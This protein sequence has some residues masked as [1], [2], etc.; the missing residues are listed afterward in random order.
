MKA[1]SQ[2]AGIQLFN[3]NRQIFKAPAPQGQSKE[4]RRVMIRLGP[5]HDARKVGAFELRQ[6][7]KELES[8]KS[9]VSDVWSVPSGV[10]I[11]APTPAKA[12][13]I[14]QSK[15]ARK[16]RMG[17]ATKVRCL[18]GTQDPME[19]LLQE[20][21]ATVRDYLPIRYMN[22]T[23]KSQNDEPYGNI[24][25]CVPKAKA[26]KFPSRLRIFGEDN[27]ERIEPSLRIMQ[28]NVGES[29]SAHN[30][31]LALAN[32]NSIDILLLLKLW[33]FTD[34]SIR[35]S[36]AHRSFTA[37]SNARLELQ[38]ETTDLSR[39]ILQITITMGDHRWAPIWNI[40][41]APVR[42]DE[43][44]SDLDLLLKSPNLPFYV[45]GDFNLRHPLRDMTNTSPHMA[46]QELIN[47]YNSLD[48]IL[49]NTR[50]PPTN[51]RDGTIDLVFSMDENAKCEV[52]KDLHTT[53]DHETLVTT[54]RIKKLQNSKGKLRYRDLDNEIFLRLLSN[55][56]IPLT[57]ACPRTRPPNGDTPCWNSECQA[58][59]SG[60]I[61]LE[62]K[63]LRDAVQ[64]LKRAYWRSIIEE[65]EKLS[66]VYKIVRWHKAS[67]NYLLPPL[68]DT[69]GQECAQDPQSKAVLF[70]RV[71]LLRQLETNDT[72]SNSPTV[73]KRNV[74]WYS[75]SELEAYEATC[76]ATSKSP[77]IDEITTRI[78]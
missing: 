17:N 72:P 7:I 18:D 47:W 33:I 52:R 64:R 74:P 15:A 60:P 68:R 38:K 22:W 54:I 35:K 48:L 71:L 59:R 8:D 30:I 42:A 13:S 2:D 26:N 37:F 4:D 1:E 57:G 49:L 45:G 36:K 70:H 5:E 39:D 34:L 63:D 41:N 62:K 9:L 25:I 14:M 24:R 53:S 66:D 12:A 32:K 55:I 20:E 28:G 23:R 67:Q 31:A 19:G 27:N 73:S 44:G 40:F 50:N 78:L 56:K 61:V 65:V 3:L 77:G 21:L 51:N 75:I 6:K 76:Q 58:H 11:L 43:A 16:E 69:D 46:C 29:S 10:A